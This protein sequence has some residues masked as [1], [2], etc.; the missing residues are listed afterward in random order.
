M[1]IEHELDTIR[2]PAIRREGEPCRDCGAPLAA[3]Q[4]YCLECGRR[5]GDARLPF[6]ELMEDRIRRETA[7]P[8]RPPA[9]PPLRERVTP[10]YAGAG[11]GL[12]ALALLF[13]ILIGS[14]GDDQPRQVAAAPPQVISVAAPAAAGQPVAQEFTADWPADEDG[15]TVQLRSLPKDGT[16]VAAVQAAKS[17]VQS[18][19]APAVG[20]LDSD[21]FA[22]LDAGNYVIYSGV[23]KSRK[24]AKRALADLKADFSGAKVVRVSSSGGGLAAQG[25]KDALSGKKKE[26]TVG[27]NQLKDLQGLSP[28]QYEKKAKKLPD[29]TKLPGKATPKDDKKPG[30]GG[31]GDVIE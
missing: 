1:T 29:T 18:K 22:S 19:G 4:R 3:D 12:L 20:A 10:V 28:E 24:A 30:G 26:A 11:V 9:P 17:D 2:G 5:R 14:A 15:Y 27:K 25:D 6:K 31:K 16:D 7:V 23:F 8:A 21:E 13:G